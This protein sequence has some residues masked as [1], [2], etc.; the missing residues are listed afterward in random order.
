[1]KKIKRIIEKNLNGKKIVLLFLLTNLVYV[2]MLTVTIPMILSFSKGIKT[3]DMMP[4]GYDY[5]YINTLFETL[6]KKGR[7]VYLYYQIP[8]DMI[9]PFLF[10]L[11]YCLVIAYFLKKLNKFNTPYLYLCLLPV[12]AG[13]ADYGENI[14][15]IS[16]LTN[17]PEQS[18]FSMSVTTVFSILKS[19]ATSLYFVALIITLI[20]LGVKTLKGN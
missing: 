16:M 1:M 3:L 10:G 6:G 5:D 14:G 11:S 17:Y 12:I 9:Y 4:L 8:V 13:I 15:I 19:T 2:L 7:D 20:L 18:Q